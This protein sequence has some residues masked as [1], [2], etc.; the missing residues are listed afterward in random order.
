MTQE[1][2][3]SPQAKKA[4]ITAVAVVA[5]GMASYFMRE[6]H[7]TLTIPPLVVIALLYIPPKTPRGSTIR[8]MA[9]VLAMLAFN[10]SVLFGHGLTIP[11]SFPLDEMPLSFAAL[12]KTIP[13]LA[14]LLTNAAV[15]ISWLHRPPMNTPQASSHD[16]AHQETLRNS[17]EDRI[18]K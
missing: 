11:D 7:L 13:T 17:P 12:T 14:T 15:I 3:L 1:Q 2:D 18:T 9:V 16:E 4:L 8:V 5:A 10:G 6:H